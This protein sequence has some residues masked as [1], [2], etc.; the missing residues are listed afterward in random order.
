[1]SNSIVVTT[2]LDAETIDLV[3]RVASAG[4][5][6]RSKFVA[7]AVAEAVRREAA[8]LDFVQEGLDDLDAGR[9]VPHE[10]VMA[11]LDA[12]IAKHEARCRD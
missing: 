3:D 1:M 8:F 7:R 12:M 5:H 11:E 6:S 10:V 2:R 9:T 4:G